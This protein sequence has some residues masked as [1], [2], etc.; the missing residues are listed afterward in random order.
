M[1]YGLLIQREENSKKT[2]K[3]AWP[4]PGASLQTL[5]LERSSEQGFMQWEFFLM[6]LDLIPLF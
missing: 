6:K 5:M 3:E 1:E 4:L 2:E